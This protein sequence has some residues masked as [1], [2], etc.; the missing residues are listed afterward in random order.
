MKAATLPSPQ[1]VSKRPLRVGEVARPEP[2]P[3]QVLVRV[4]A[5]GVCRTDLHIVEGDLPPS[6]PGVIPGHQIVGEV[7]AGTAAG[8]TERLPV[9]TRVGVSWMGATHATCPHC[10]LGLYTL[11]HS[12]PL[13][14]YTLHPVYP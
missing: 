2:K 1:P 4:R 14:A 7:I 6:R 11:S 3:G 9:G 12:P 8:A 13:P 5:C 10:H